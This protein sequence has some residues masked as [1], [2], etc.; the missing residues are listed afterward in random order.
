M[1]IGFPFSGNNNGSILSGS[2]N[3]L[4][5]NINP[6]ANSGDRGPRPTA[7]SPAY[8]SNPYDK[9][10][11]FGRITYADYARS[12][13]SQLESALAGQRTYDEGAAPFKAEYAGNTQLQQQYATEAAYLSAKYGQTVTQWGGGTAWSPY[14]RPET[15]FIASEDQYHYDPVMVDNYHSSQFDQPAAWDAYFKAAAESDVGY[16]KNSRLEEGYNSQ[17][18][19]AQRNNQA[20]QQQNDSNYAAT[21]ASLKIPQKTTAMTTG[22]SRVA[23]DVLTRGGGTGLGISTAQ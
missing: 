14:V 23:A 21:L 12:M 22:I 2:W 15:P 11:V 19:I 20:Q 1:A 3:P 4:N 10:S 9:R 8:F 7:I 6:V 16:W 5:L 18:A 13:N 17:L